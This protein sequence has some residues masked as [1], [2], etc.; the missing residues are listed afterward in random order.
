[1]YGVKEALSLISFEYYNKKNIYSE[2]EILENLDVKIYEPNSLGYGEIIIKGDSVTRCYYNDVQKTKEAFDYKGYYHTKDIG[3]IKD[4]NLYIVGSTVRKIVLDD[5][6][7][8]YPQEIEEIMQDTKK[9][10]NVNVFEKNGVIIS[11]V[12]TELD[13]KQVDDVIYEV[14]QKL[15]DYMKIGKVNIKKRKLK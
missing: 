10:L 1:M 5:G 12:V 6:N 14:N 2:G 7:V 8:I 9:F 13:E 3:Y 15:P 11:N 4:N